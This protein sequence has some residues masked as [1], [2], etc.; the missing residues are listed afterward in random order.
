MTFTH[1]LVFMETESVK[2]KVK[3]PFKCIFTIILFCHFQL[4]LQRNFLCIVY[5]LPDES[6]EEQDLE[7]DF[8]P[9]DEIAFISLPSI[10]EDTDREKLLNHAS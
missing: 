9:E 1:S 4:Y 2:F 7:P 6:L 10:E 8:V 5:L 3:L